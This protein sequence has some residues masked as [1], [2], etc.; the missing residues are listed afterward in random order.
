MVEVLVGDGKEG[1]YGLG[2]MRG[3]LG[4]G[5]LSGEGSWGM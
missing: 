4:I 2:V 5:C 3:G 1:G